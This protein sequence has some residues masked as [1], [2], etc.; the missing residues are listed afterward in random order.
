MR[1]AGGRHAGLLGRKRIQRW[2]L[3]RTG[4]PAVW[5]NPHHAQQWVRLHVWPSHGRFAGLLGLLVQDRRVT[6]PTHRRRPFVAVSSGELHTCALREDGAPL[7]WGD[8]THGQASPPEVERFVAVSSGE[9]HTCALREDG[10]VGCWGSN[11]NGRS[12]PPGRR[13]IRVLSSGSGHTCALRS[14]G[15]V[16]CWGATM[17]ARR[18]RRRMSSSWL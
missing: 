3:R 16:A 11:R 18:H 12:T 15:F 2:W 17:K 9:Q 5:R 4:F 13:A 14:D 7:C 8:N 10:T 6:Q 1:S